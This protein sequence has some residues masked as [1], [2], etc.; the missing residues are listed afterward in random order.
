MRLDC[1]TVFG[2]RSGRVTT[3]DGL[4]RPTYPGFGVSSSFTAGAIRAISGSWQWVF[5]ATRFYVDGS[6]SERRRHHLHESVLPRAVKEAARTAGIA[7]PPTCH[8]LRHS[9]ATHL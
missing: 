6:T 5:S 8:T 9:F 2:Q 1:S 7:R 3:A 4:K